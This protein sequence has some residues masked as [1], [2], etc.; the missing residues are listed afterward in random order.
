ITI[1]KLS[2]D[3]DLSEHAMDIDK[4]VLETPYSTV[5]SDV[6]FSF[7]QTMSDFENTVQIDADFKKASVSTTDLKKFYQ[8]FGY[9]Q[10]I[11]FQGKMVGVLNDFQL[12]NLNLHGLR[13]TAINGQ[14][15]LKNIF[16]DHP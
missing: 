16:G 11:D 2:A 15:N 10:R 7:D 5:K 13:H 12:R 4:F 8:A 9:G 6:H 1:D 14:V 3:F